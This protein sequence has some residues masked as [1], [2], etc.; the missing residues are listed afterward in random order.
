[1][2]YVPSGIDLSLNQTQPNIYWDCTLT[3]Q[4]D[5][6]SMYVPPGIDLSLYQTQ[7]NIYWGCTLTVQ[8]DRT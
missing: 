2:M 7:P 8:D 4:D 5:G 3:V 1:M 6:T